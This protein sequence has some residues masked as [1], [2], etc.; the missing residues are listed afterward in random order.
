MYSRENYYLSISQIIFHHFMC[1]CNILKLEN[2]AYL[3]LEDACLYLVG[4]I[5]QRSAYKVF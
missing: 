4:Q 5:I 2:L 3:D 1:S